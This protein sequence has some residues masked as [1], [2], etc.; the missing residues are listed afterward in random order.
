MTFHNR[1]HELEDVRRFVRSARPEM[2]II[3]GR[4]GVGKTML[5]AEALQSAPHLFYQASTRTLPQQ[6]EDMTAALRA[7]AP[8]MAMG[9]PFTSLDAFLDAI[10]L[11]ARR[12]SPQPTVVVFDELPYLALSE[13][14]LPSV[15]QRWWDQLRR[16]DPPNLK[17]FLCG[18]LVS[19]MEEQTLAVTGPL[20]NRRT[21]QMKLDPLGYADAAL[22]YP[23]YAPTER[24]AAY[25][26]W[27]GL[28][29]YLAEL[30]PD[31][32]LWSNV[33]DGV[34]IHTSRLADEPVWLRFADLRSDPVYESILRAIATGS[35]RPGKIASAVGK[36]RA[37]DIM[38]HLRRL[39]DLGIVERIVPIHERH[40]PRTKNASY[41]L[42]DHYVAFWYR[43]VDRSR[44]LLAMRLYDQA[45][46]LIQQQIDEYIASDVF[47][48]LC[49]QHLWRAL[50]ERRLPEDLIFEDV[51]AWWR[52]HNG[53]SDELDIVAMDRGH[54]VLVGEC[55]WSTQPMDMRDLQGLRSALMKASQ[56]LQPIDHPWRALF[57]KS[58]FS[59]DLL[60]L[61]RVPDER[62]LL[63]T[64]NDLYASGISEIA[65]GD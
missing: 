59:D 20:H 8:E 5:L 1:V 54:A 60:A 39:C 42:V 44:H 52:G 58:G 24:I 43:F 16:Q 25:A 21:G 33:K 47:E 11:L 29:S 48:D 64:P 26:I 55:K 46:G 63:F 41:R 65:K 4:R 13:P 30:D 27:G 35:R 38:Y 14:A 57:S 6:L 36:P 31:R 3:Y 10:A 18:S 9:G 49:R 53:E 40:M 7:Y 56:D 28:P 22:F 12:A 62:L 51:G 32:D 2:V 19:W 61:A 15:M 45:V 50:A 34:L 17:L 37:D 23:S